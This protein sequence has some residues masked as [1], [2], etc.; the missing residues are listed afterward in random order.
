MGKEREYF[1]NRVQKKRDP[2]TDIA[3]LSPEAGFVMNLEIFVDALKKGH[4]SSC[5]EKEE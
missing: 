2:I 3:L 5:N 1:L 4:A